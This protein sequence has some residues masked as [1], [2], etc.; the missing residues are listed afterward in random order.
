MTAE[1]AIA[2]ATAVAL[3]ADSAVTIGDQKIYNSALK[4]FSL[5]K[6]A[7]VGVMIYGNAD[8]MDVPW[9]T[10]IKTY[11][12]QLSGETYETLNEYATDFVSYLNDNPSLFPK[13]SQE[14][15]IFG[16]VTAYFNLIRDEFFEDLHPLLK[17]NGQVTASEVSRVL[18]TVIE[19]HHAALKKEKFAAGMSEKF[20][21]R[22]R[23][24]YFDQFKGLRQK[25]FEKVRVSG[26]LASRLYDIAAYVHTKQVFSSGVSGLV[27]A[28]YGESEI[29]PSVIAFDVEG[30]VEDKLKYRMNSDKCHSIETGNECRIIAFAQDDM[31][32]TFMNGINPQVLGFVESY[33]NKVFNRL[34]ELLDEEKYSSEDKKKYRTQALRLLKSFF[35]EFSEH[36]H[37]E[38]ANPVLR[39]VMVLP[40]DELA[41]MAEALVNLTAFKRRMTEARETVGGPIDVVVISKGDGLIWVKRKHYFSP[42][43]NQHFFANY[44]RGISNGD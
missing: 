22:V 27:V 42:E 23:E 4:L 38:Q 25:V 6:I 30:V 17:E 12:K 7:P 16:N 24:K 32:T 37:A 28:G 21:K 44:F 35:N 11:R 10:L 29:Y 18:S 43:L 19:R 20:N 13:E 33:L 39:M 36:L 2:N 14:R 9:E 41:A 34:P 31:V 1:V 40:K 26:H 3:A 15:W 8:L 5:S